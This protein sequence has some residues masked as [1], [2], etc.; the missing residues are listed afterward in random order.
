MKHSRSFTQLGS[1]AIKVAI[2]LSLVPALS[3]PTNRLWAEADPSP[4]RDQQRAT[5][6]FAIQESFH[7][8]YE[9]YKNRVV[10]ISTERTVQ[11]QPNPM[12]NDP[13]FRRFFR[14]PEGSQTQRQTGLGSGFIVSAD[15]YVCTNHHVVADV[16]SVTVRIDD[17]EYEAEVI[18]SDELTDIALLK[19]QAPGPFE[20][21][22]MGNSDRVQVGDW[23]I[24]IGNPF[25]LDRT[26]TVGVVS[27]VAR[28]EL[29]PLGNA[30][31]QTD[32]SINPGNSG[33]PLL[34]LDGEVIGVNRMIYSQTGGSMGI[35]FAIPIN[36]VHA[37]L[38]QLREHGKV[39][40]AY[41]GAQIAPVSQDVARQLGLPNTNG[42]IIAQVLPNSPAAQAGL[43]PN[44]VILKVAGEVVEG[45]AEL[46]R[47]ISVIPI[48]QNVAFEV[49]R[50]GRVVQ[51]S[52]TLQERP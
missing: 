24:A 22:F 18:G 3:G 39:R 41:I 10:F 25:G 13:L 34:N 40:R 52:I 30:H 19:I 14:V 1:I 37:V 32:A 35:G 9:L 48:G 42:A 7:R 11:A 51:L 26:F 5:S 2:G 6:A 12:L 31:I 47:K 27:A 49:W 4:I 43:R 33:G 46:I 15:G 20:S 50:E 23:A 36:T 8:I 16:D 29:D 17:H 45:P 38:D 28:T 44:D 21:V